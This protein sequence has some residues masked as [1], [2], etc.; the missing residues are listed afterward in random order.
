MEKDKR[1]C[2]PEIKILQTDNLKQ[3]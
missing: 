1:N 2:D 3:K